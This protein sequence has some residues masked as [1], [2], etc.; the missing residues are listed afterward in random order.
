[1]SL[2]GLVYSCRSIINCNLKFLPSMIPMNFMSPNHQFLRCPYYC[3]Y[4]YF[5]L[6]LNSSF[7]CPIFLLIISISFVFHLS[8]VYYFMLLIL[9][10]TII[11]FCFLFLVLRFILLSCCNIITSWLYSWSNLNF[12]WMDSGYR[13]F[14]LSFIRTNIVL[15]TFYSHLP[16]LDYF[17]EDRR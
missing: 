17:W 16:G 14:D 5:T 15:Q 7:R 3:H 2:P 9:L 4:Y 8:I 11:D 12:F 13:L 6:I 1:M 10:S